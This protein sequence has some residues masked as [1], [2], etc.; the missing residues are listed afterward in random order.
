[1]S[2][3]ASLGPYDTLPPGVKRPFRNQHEIFL[4][5]FEFR[6]TRSPMLAT[7]AVVALRDAKADGGDE[8]E[9]LTFLQRSDP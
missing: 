1:M 6:Q 5:L 9:M 2:G 7:R 4:W 3:G 8:R